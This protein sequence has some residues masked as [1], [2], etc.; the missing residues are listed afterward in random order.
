LELEARGLEEVIRETGGDKE[1]LNQS[2][3]FLI[4]QAV[5]KMISKTSYN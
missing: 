2:L 4:G 3:I 1:K 5:G